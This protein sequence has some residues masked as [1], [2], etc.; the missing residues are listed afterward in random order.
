MFLLTAAFHPEEV[1]LVQSE[2]VLHS[3]LEGCKSFQSATV[4]ISVTGIASM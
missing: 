2:D 3:L 4:P 1:M